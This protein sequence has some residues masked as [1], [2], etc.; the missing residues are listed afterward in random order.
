MDQW[1]RQLCR[2]IGLLVLSTT[3]AC[4]QSKVDQKLA[5][6]DG[7]RW[8]SGGSFEVSCDATGVQGTQILAVAT[9]ARKVDD[10]VRE[11][12]R[13]GVRAILFRGV[14][15]N[16]CKVDP[17]FRPADMTP[18]ADAYF[19]KFF[20]E[21]GQ[22]LAYVEYVGDQIEAR[23]A[24]GKDVRIETSVVINVQR[25]R[26]DLEQAGLIKSMSDIFRRP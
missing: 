19:D 11:S 14:I 24:V 18:T 8:F 5:K 7:M 4:A 23:T 13:N 2:V 6:T 25:L 10:A 17:L 15:T 26:T 22:Y 21:G 9:T 12:R 3:V 20:A 1:C 16:A